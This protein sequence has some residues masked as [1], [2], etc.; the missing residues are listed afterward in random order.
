MSTF[1]RDGG[2]SPVV[3]IIIMI[4]I[5]ILLAALLLLMIQI[6][7]FDLQKATPSFLEIQG[8]FHVDESG[9][10]NFDSRVVMCHTGV[11]ILQN[12]DLWAEFYRNDV[13]LGVVI[14]TLNGEAFIKTHHYGVQTLG[15]LGCRGATWTP[16]EKIS[17]DFSDGTFHPGDKV[18]VDIYT[19]PSGTLV[20]RYVATA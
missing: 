13:K 20:S 7:S 19:R 11:K 2:V 15:G 9:N 12:S 1:D 16:G 14:E 10:Q 6:P 3:G 5:V 17:I 8:F 4:A 18:R